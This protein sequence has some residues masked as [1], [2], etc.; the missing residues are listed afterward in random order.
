MTRPSTSPVRLD[1]DL[2]ALIGRGVS[3]ALA[4]RNGRLRPSV[5]RGWGAKVL[6][7]GRIRVFVAR[8]PSRACQADILDNGAVAVVFADVATLRTIQLKGFDARVLP[9]AEGESAEI[10]AYRDAFFAEI[11]KLDTP[12][13]VA[14]GMWTDGHV[15]VEFTP[16]ELYDQTPG[17]GAGSRVAP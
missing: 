5:T 1:P 14:M 8:D 4:A 2:S 13:S 11:G 17:P 7:D 15:A 12:L 9:L 3:M 6:P 10:L 16:A